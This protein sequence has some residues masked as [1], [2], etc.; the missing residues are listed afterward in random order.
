MPGYRPDART[1]ARESDTR[2]AAVPCPG[3]RTGLPCSPVQRVITE[4]NQVSTEEEEDEEEE[5]EEG[6]AVEEEEV[7]YFTGSVRF[8]TLSVRALPQ[9]PEM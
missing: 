1:P 6:E 8:K 5:D 2:P 9:M 3:H 7:A 4:I